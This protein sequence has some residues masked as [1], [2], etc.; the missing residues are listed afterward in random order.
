MGLRS[1]RLHFNDFFLFLG[2]N[3]KKKQQ[4]RLF[5]IAEKKKCI[6]FFVWLH[7]FVFKIL[8]KVRI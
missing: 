8:T 7:F 4:A 5:C 6:R 2:S 1:F 3:G